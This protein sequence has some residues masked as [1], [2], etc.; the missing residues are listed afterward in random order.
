MEQRAG[1]VQRAF[2]IARSGKV[3]GIAALR[4]QLTEEHYV[5][6]AQF[7]AGR[8]LRNQLARIIIEARTAK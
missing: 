7:L 3:A 6:N 5:N 8:S 2:E 1:V 4:S